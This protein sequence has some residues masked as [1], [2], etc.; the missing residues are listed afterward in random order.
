M[1]PLPLGAQYGQ[2]RGYPLSA[3]RT[4]LNTTTLIVLIAVLLVGSLVGYRRASARADRARQLTALRARPAVIA[5]FATPEGAILML[6]E[7]FRRRDLEAAVAAK[8]FAT[9]AE[10]EIGT[11][12][13]PQTG[14]DALITER[15]A[16]LEA[17]FRAL[18]TTSWPEFT[19]VESYFLDRQPYRP[20]SGHSSAR[21]LAVVTELNRFAQGG[22]S[23]QRILVAETARGWRV[24]NPL[25]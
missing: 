22:H 11:G 16:S 1:A 25:S 19:G 21:D 17:Q 4:Y 3:D 15:A 23:E 9:E 5:D 6:E 20:P 7:A 24:L 12:G 13:A 10:L 2:N 14:S 8:D 18:M